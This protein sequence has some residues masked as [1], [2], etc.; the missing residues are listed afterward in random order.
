[1]NMCWLLGKNELITTEKRFIVSTYISNNH[2]EK[3]ALNAP[4]TITQN[5]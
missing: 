1:M 3:N 4:L 5:V 2:L